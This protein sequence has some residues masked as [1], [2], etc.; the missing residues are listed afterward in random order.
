MTRGGVGTG[1]GDGVRGGASPADLLR[2]FSGVFVAVT[3]IVVTLALVRWV[4]TFPYDAAAIAFPGRS[5]TTVMATARIIAIGASSMAVGCTVFALFFVGHRE[6][7]VLG[8]DAFAA[9]RAASRAAWVWFVAALVMIPMTAADGVGRT[10]AQMQERG[11][12]VE[13]WIAQEQ[14]KAWTAAAV[15]ALLTAIITGS[16][17]GWTSQM[18]SLWLSLPGAMSPGFVGNSGQGVDHDL[19]TNM[20]ILHSGAAAILVGVLVALWGFL[21][22]R[23]RGTTGRDSGTVSVIAAAGVGETVRRYR[24]L[25]ARTLPVL[26]ISGAG[27][28]WFQLGDHSWDGRYGRLVLLQVLVFAGLTV[29][30]VVRARRPPSAVVRLRALV[31][32]AALLLLALAAAGALARIPSPSLLETAASAMEIYIGY[33]VPG[34]W[35]WTGLLVDWRVDTLW[36]LI[37]LAMIAWYLWTARSLR[38]RGGSWPVYRDVLWTTAWVTVVLLTSSGINTWSS[39]QF[40]MHMA[41]H[42]VLNLF[43]PPLIVAAGPFTLIHDASRPAEERRG[44]VTGPREWVRFLLRSTLVR[45]LTNPLVALTIYVV[46]LFGLYFTPIFDYVIR[47]HWGHQW[48]NVHFLLTGFLFFWPVLGVDPGVRRLGSLGRIGMLLAIM[49]FHALYGVIMMTMDGLLGSTF[50]ESLDVLSLDALVAD[51]RLGGVLAWISGEI[52]LLVAVV[53]LLVVW[54]RQERGAA[55]RSRDAGDHLGDLMEELRSQRR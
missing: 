5:S 24:A 35:T 14:P 30:A 7:G 29:V 39:A 37:S 48:M 15:L 27:L 6:D 45:T 40:S 42:L 25:V 16:S 1:S 18:V 31:P 9:T 53:A 28:A 34:P 13:L 33:S 46:T 50:Y 55:G 20:L 11:A 10:V 26:A 54:L 36:L 12:F 21:R 52:P 4:G 23:A 38:R 49:P 22:R 19:A 47:F 17:V 43:V 51:Q 41:M 3:G 2:S 32:D 44:G 8:V